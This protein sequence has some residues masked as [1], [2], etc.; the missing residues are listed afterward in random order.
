[1]RR[2]TA[3]DLVRRDD[4]RYTYRF[5][6]ALRASP[7]PVYWPSEEEQWAALAALRCPVLLLRGAGSPFPRETA[8]RMAITIPDCRLIEIPD[9]GDFPNIDNPDVFFGAVRQFLVET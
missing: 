2:W 5:E 8:E 4:G 3:Y 7:R 1:M 9:S 6:P